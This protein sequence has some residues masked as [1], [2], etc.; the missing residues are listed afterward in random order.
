MSDTVIT[1]EIIEKVQEILKDGQYDGG[2][3]TADVGGHAPC[4]DT[5]YHFITVLEM[6]L[7]HLKIKTQHTPILI[8]EPP[9]NPEYKRRR[10]MNKIM[11]WYVVPAR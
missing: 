1:K 2:T 6:A 4:S 9:D 7:Q 3:F 10:N 5:Q 8:P 11:D